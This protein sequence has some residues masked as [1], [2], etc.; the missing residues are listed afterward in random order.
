M[1]VKWNIYLL[2]LFVQNQLMYADKLSGINN[3]KNIYIIIIYI[4]ESRWLTETDRLWQ[5][6]L[7]IDQ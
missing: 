3:Y 4:L 1:N 5:M 2:L 6:L 7:T